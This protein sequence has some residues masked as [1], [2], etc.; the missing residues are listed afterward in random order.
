MA[1]TLNINLTPGSG[2]KMHS[3]SAQG[4]CAWLNL[5]T[6]V[7]LIATLSAQSSPKDA[8]SR[9]T[10]LPTPAAGDTL[11]SCANGPSGSPTRKTTHILS[12]EARIA[13][14]D[15]YA[16]EPQAS[17]DFRNH[18]SAL[19]VPMYV[20]PSDKTGLSGGL[21][22]GWT[23]QKS[24]GT[25]FGSSPEQV[26]EFEHMGGDFGAADDW[27]TWYRS[28]PVIGCDLYCPRNPIGGGD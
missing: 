24:I 12:L 3:A 27:R 1:L 20:I 13:V 5:S 10:C 26:D 7:A 21:V 19:H 22:L 16:L 18:L 4:G 6:P 23:S 15:R 2:V 9:T 28:G 17:R 8:T 11:L 25:L 14:N